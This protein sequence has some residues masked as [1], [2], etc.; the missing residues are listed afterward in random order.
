M[1][2]RAKMAP[3][4][5]LSDSSLDNLQAQVGGKPKQTL[6]KAQVRT[7]ATTPRDQR[8]RRPQAATEPPQRRPH[9]KRQQAKSRVTRG[10]GEMRSSD[11]A[12]PRRQSEK[13]PPPRPTEAAPRPGDRRAP[14]SLLINKRI[15]EQE[16]Q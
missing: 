13:Q 12:R 10:R 16:I 11:A 7:G 14:N 1:R 6:G 8:P 9:P 3:Y 15:T 4:A 2:P 5:S